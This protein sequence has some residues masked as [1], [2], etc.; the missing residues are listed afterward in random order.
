MSGHLGEHLQI[1]ECDHILLKEQEV[2]SKSDVDHNHHW[3]EVVVTVMI[4]SMMILA[5]VVLSVVFT[6]LSMV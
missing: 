4:L 5:T 2:D 1:G 6:M 3:T